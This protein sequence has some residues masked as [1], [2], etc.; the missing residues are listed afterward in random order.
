MEEK[1]QEKRPLVFWKGGIIKGRDLY[2]YGWF[3]SQKTPLHLRYLAERM[4]Q[5]GHVNTD[6]E[7]DRFAALELLANK[8]KEI[9]FR[10]AKKD[11]LPFLR[12]PERVDIWSEE[13]FTSI[14]REQL[15]T[16]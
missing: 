2:D 5:T 14:T 15:L 9:D 16:V 10:K 1:G 4:K 8:F 7:L 6:L 13:F 12:D 11:I 3:I